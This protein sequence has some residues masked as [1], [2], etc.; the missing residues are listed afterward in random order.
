MSVFLVLY[1]CRRVYSFSL[2]SFVALFALGFADVSLSTA[3][4]DIF[5]I[6]NGCVIFTLHFF[7]VLCLSSSI[8]IFY[9]DCVIF[10]DQIF[11]LS[12]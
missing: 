12:K 5:V 1:K 2:K 7:F 8:I 6:C 11:I 4:A 9:S 3:T 10:V